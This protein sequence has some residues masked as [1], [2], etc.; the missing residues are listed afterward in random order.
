MAYI[1]K[2]DREEEHGWHRY[3]YSV[4]HNKITVNRWIKLSVRHWNEVQSNQKKKDYPYYFDEST[5]LKLMKFAALLK[6]F[7]GAFAGKPIVLEDWQAYLIAN[8]YGIKRKSDNKRR[9]T[10]AFVFIGRKNG[11]STLG[12][13]LMLW[14]LFS[15]PGAGVYAVATK[16]DQAKISFGMVE[17]F[18]KNN[19][20]IKELVR[21][22]YQTITYEKQASKI[23]ALSSEHDTL[24]GLNPSFVLADEIAQYRNSKVI[25]VMRSGMYS[26][27]EP[28][29]FQITTGSENMSSVGFMEFERAQKVLQGIVE[30]PSF[31][32]LLYTLDEKDNWKDSTKY[33]KANPNLNVSVPLP[34]LEDA[35]DQA[36]TAP[37]RESEFKTKNLNLFENITQSWISDK[38][39]IVAYENYT[40]HD[41]S[42][43]DLS[44]VA[45]VGSVD[46]SKRFDF[47]SYTLCWYLEDLNIYL[48]KHRLYIPTDQI[49][50]KMRKD[51]P[52]IRAWINDKWI[53]PTPGEVIDYTFLTADIE[54]DMKQ[55][56][57]L[58]VAYDPAL[59]SS[60]LYLC[61]EKIP[62]LDI[63]AIPQNN[64]TMGPFNA[65]Y[66]ESVVGER[67]ACT[68]PVWRW[69]LSNTTIRTG[70]TGLI[71]LD[72]VEDRKTNRR[73]DAVVTSVI[74]HGRLVAYG[75]EG[76]E[77]EYVPLENFS[78]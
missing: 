31:F 13:V 73:I 2:K 76:K 25:D 52:L 47:T 6:H 32:P 35:R 27:E 9:Y 46:L 40:K 56:R 59:S 28:M 20:S 36:I 74:A 33:I 16:R 75:R 45:C 63:V 23:E 19:P 34:A 50:E 60:F 5:P 51:S 12:A 39:A 69:M 18:V 43:Y 30:D 54:S 4:T 37:Y 78:Y 26:R 3:A 57:I 42:N 15:E 11:K 77:I 71:S 58:E 44:N 7:E 70:G 17:Q 48:F 72:K 22:H 14:S 62:E 64:T 1:R 66:E 61:E 29:L 65:A 41:L 8:L 67:V 10:S 53:T 21:I 49:E 68:N 24:D 38:K 55:Y